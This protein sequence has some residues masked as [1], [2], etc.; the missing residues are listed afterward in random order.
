MN[1]LLIGSGG[2]EH[3]LAWGIARSSE[4]DTLF[5]AP[6]NPGTAE[7]G[8]N[9]ELN[10]SD[11]DA[12][13]EFIQ[14]EDIDLTV[15]GPEQPLVDGIADFLE[16][17]GHPVFGPK[18]QAAMLEGSKEFAKDFMKRQ[19]IPTAAYEVFAQDEFD[20][21]AEYIRSEG[22]YPV[23]LKADGLAG[24]KGVL[25]PESGQEAM[26]ALNELQSGSLSDAA[27]R[28]VIE[29]FMVGEEASVFAICD[30]D[31]FK[32]IGN[33]QDH[34]RVGEGD[35]GLN[36]GGMGAY[37]PAPVVTDEILSK[38]ESEIIKPTIEGMKSEGNQYT[39][40]LYVGLMITEEGPKVV[41]YNCRFGDPE[42]QVIIPRLKSDLL[43]VIAACT[44]GKLGETAI[45]FD[46]QY[47]CTVVLASGGYPT[48]YE[49]GKEITGIDKVESAQV[50]HAG[51]KIQDGK[52]T[53]NGGR[54]LNVVGNGATL[55]EAI[56]NA[57]SEI[58][59]IHFDKA[60]YRSDI[61]AKGLKH[62]K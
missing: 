40:F 38:I 5:I 31:S 16:A 25:I 19:N 56:D 20:K 14:S 26:Q 57:Y 22:K 59:K 37:S 28:L 29:E 3:A 23:V 39:G 54:V 32:V 13:L 21:A 18:Q 2:R 45:E 10:I 61:G 8:Q 9:V 44:Q 42:C 4:L 50:F 55:Q 46:D 41:E 15:V 24:G 35:T 62:V 6:G 53:T 33:A 58:S 7:L 27:S 47:R 52:L 48:E 30:G 36:T 34:K 12:V 49:K 43:E 17:K 51:T 1:V 11:H 60:F